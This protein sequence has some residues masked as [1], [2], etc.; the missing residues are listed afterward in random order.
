MD[1][2]GPWFGKDF[3]DKRARGCLRRA[4]MRR[5]KE[6]AK[7]KREDPSLVTPYW[8][9]DFND[10]MLYESTI[11]CC[12]VVCVERDDDL[13]VFEA[14]TS[15]VQN[16]GIC[17]I[18][19][20]EIPTRE[21]TKRQLKDIVPSCGEYFPE[22]TKRVDGKWQTGYGPFENEKYIKSLSWWYDEWED[23]GEEE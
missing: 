17:M 21:F 6:Y 1:N 9:S 14:D 8:K 11:K 23:I 4:L 12:G 10:W 18:A 2:K 20:F 7:G 16:E 19:R 5:A 3:D 22:R 15:G 13:C